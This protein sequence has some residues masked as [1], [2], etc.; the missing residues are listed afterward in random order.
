MAKMSN[1]VPTTPLGEEIAGAS[2]YLFGAFGVGEATSFWKRGSLRSGS[3]IGSSRSSAGVSGTLN[4]VGLNT[5]WIAVSAKRRWLGWVPS[6]L[7][8]PAQGSQLKRG[9]KA[10]LSRNLGHPLIDKSE[11]G[12]FIAKTHISQREIAN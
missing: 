7:R 3:N 12:G 9:Q 2:H 11:R 6:C 5:V 8:L 1:Q 10:H 4:P